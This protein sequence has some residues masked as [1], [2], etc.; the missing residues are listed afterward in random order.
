MSL[1]MCGGGSGQ[2]SRAAWVRLHCGFLLSPV[3]LS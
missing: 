2:V 3:A 1:V